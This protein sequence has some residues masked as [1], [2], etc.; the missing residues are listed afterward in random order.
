MAERS[1]CNYYAFSAK[2]TSPY[3]PLSTKSSTLFISALTVDSPTNNCAII[4]FMCKMSQGTIIIIITFQCIQTFL[5][6][7][8]T[9]NC[10]RYWNQYVHSWINF[11]ILPDDW[12]RK[13][14]SGRRLSNF[15]GNL[16][17][18]REVQI[19]FKECYFIG[20]EPRK[21]EMIIFYRK[22]EKFHFKNIW[23]PEI[24]C[25]K[26]FIRLNN[27][28]RRKQLDLHQWNIIQAYFSHFPS[29]LL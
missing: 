15:L 10:C 7:F 22:I 29:W 1:G 18:K 9:L 12:R 17:L 28:Y 19:F 3:Y 20:S 21:K 13:L 26:L 6:R 11:K 14:E 8:V 16:I 25:F 24:F 4:S 2:A 23:R 5:P 27:M